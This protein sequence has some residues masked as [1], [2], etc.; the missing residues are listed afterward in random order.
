[1]AFLRPIPIYRPF[2]GRYIGWYRYFQKF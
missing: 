2:M 1:M